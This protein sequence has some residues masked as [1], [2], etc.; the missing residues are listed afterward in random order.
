ML[1]ENNFGESVPDEVTDLLGADVTT[2]GSEDGASRRWFL[3]SGVLG[4]A[5]VTGLSGLAAGAPDTE[6]TGLE[7]IAASDREIVTLVDGIA[8]RRLFKLILRGPD[9]GLVRYVEDPIQRATVALERSASVD[10]DGRISIPG[11]SFTD[12][13]VRSDPFVV[14]PEYE[15]GDLVDE[16]DAEGPTVEATS[17]QTVTANTTPSVITRS[18]RFRQLKASCKYSGFS[19]YTHKFKGV[20]FTLSKTARDVGFGTL[21]S[22]ICFVIGGGLAGAVICGAIASYI[23]SVYPG[24]RNFT[25]GGNDTDLGLPGFKSP[26]TS[27][28][29]AAKYGATLGE[30]VPI[31]LSPGHV[32]R[33]LDAEILFPSG[34]TP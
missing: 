2:V 18:A 29:V 27:I 32:E 30:T 11:L 13:L 3:K 26:Y 10:S 23:L 33:Q 8:Y 7:R 4:A 34:Y 16:S 1:E 15:Y 19:G 28:R 31:G 24:G 9:A 21:S 20:R 6:G 12:L 17:D 25:V 22:A 5:S 14:A